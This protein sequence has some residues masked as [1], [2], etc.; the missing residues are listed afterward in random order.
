MSK[1]NSQLFLKRSLIIGLV[2]VLAAGSLAI[3]IHPGKASAALTYV[4]NSTAS[5]AGVSV[6]S[7]SITA[8]S[9]MSSGQVEVAEL[10]SYITGGV[11][12]GLSIT[13]P[14]GWTI[15]GSQQNTSRTFQDAYYH[16]VTSSEPS[17]YT[18]SYSNSSYALIGISVFSGENTKSPID[19]QAE[20]VN[21]S[22]TTQTAPAVSL[23]YS[24]DMA[25]PFISYG[26][27][28]TAANYST[29]LT[30]L[31]NFSTTNAGQFAA[32]QAIT[33]SGNT[34][35]FQ[36]T[37]S[38]ATTSL[39]DTV[40]I[41]PASA[42]LGIQFKS[43]TTNT[44]GGK[45][46]CSSISLSTPSGWASGDL[47]MTSVTWNTSSDSL[48]APAGWTQIDTTITD[49]GFALADF[50]HLATSSEPSSYTWTFS[51]STQVVAALSDYSGVDSTNPID[52]S[53]TAVDTS[54]STSHA[55]PSVTTTKPD[56]ML[57][58][59]WAYEVAT[60]TS[61]FPTGDTID[62]NLSN[63][64][65]LSTDGSSAGNLLIGTAGATGTM[66]A[67]SGSKTN[68]LMHSIAL[69][70]YLPIPQLITPSNT[71]TDLT[72][73]P[74]FQLV[75]ASIDNSPLQ[76]EIQLCADSACSTVLQ[77]YDQ[78]TSQTGWSG[79]DAD[80]GTAYIGSS[81]IAN[82]TTATYTSQ[83]PLTAGTQ[84]WWRGYDY[85]T[86]NSTWSLPS[87]IHSFTTSY[88]PAAP[89][90][91][92]PA[93]GATDISTE[94]EF[95]LASTDQNGDPLEYKIQLCADS[96]CAIVL[97]SWDETATQSGWSGQDSNN[98]TAY[99][100]STTS[101]SASALAYYNLA[102][103]IAQLTP[104]TTYYWR[105][106]A[107]NPTGSDQWGPASTIQSFTVNQS[108]TRILSGTIMQ[109]TIL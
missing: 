61:S 28:I 31:W 83:S 101:A 63:S 44:C 15:I 26:S 34:S 87:N 73:Y 8:P 47:F 55:A 13:A 53:A 16:V 64:G 3:F 98:Y 7:Q 104:G 90:L 91:F 57:V 6:T 103:A 19:T 38:S 65:A 51:G 40:A 84:Y 32:Y 1:K 92:S 72:L 5:S 79:Q 49:S 66:T 27:N 20:Q 88:L 39:A 74:T 21:S 9:G 62:W 48:T 41:A 12:P 45:S 17:S 67:T 86:G 95:Q 14:S 109:G 50:Y 76:Y 93:N 105:A 99:A 70:A 102:N 36:T 4:S 10:T 37:T 107:I 108:E 80:S 69:R 68:A 11:G 35:T 29:G 54:N 23:S 18:W 52:V 43:S 56:D 42:S 71:A 58:N 96:A 78:Q 81:T 22:S 94:P 60:T 82:S 59:I 89:T 75:N 25:L 30:Q 77:T 24:G 46:L 33:N 106:Y 97:Y 100:S 85:D 2:I